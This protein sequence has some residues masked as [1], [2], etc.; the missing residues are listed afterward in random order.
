MIHVLIAEDEP[1]TL[2][3]IAAMVE[4]ADGAF[5][6]VGTA[7]NGKEA[8]KQIEQKHVDVVMTDIRM[9]VMDG[10]ELM[11]QIKTRYSHIILVVLSGYQDYEYMAHAIRARSLDYLLKPVSA[12]AMGQLLGRVKTQYLLESR[13]R[14]SRSLALHLN[15]AVGAAE[16]GHPDVRLGVCLFCAGGLPRG[17]DAEM[18]PAAQLWAQHALEPL[19]SRIV[20]GFTSFTWEFMGATPVERILVY[21][22]QQSTLAPWAKCLHETLLNQGGI[23]VSCTAL[24]EGVP[25][26]QINHQLKRLRQ[27]LRAHIR[28]GKSLFVSLPLREDHG[29][30]PAPAQDW[31]AAAKL[32][33]L[34]AEGRVGQA[35]PFRRELFQRMEREGWTQA[36]VGRL[37]EQAATILDRDERPQVRQAASGYG[38]ALAEAV[39]TALSLRELEK[40]L[41]SLAPPEGTGP[42]EQPRIREVAGAIEAY[43]RDHYFEHI[44]N[45]TLA[46]QFG[47]VPSY[48]SLLFRQQ[49]RQSPS[50]YLT[51][52]R[53]DEAKKLMQAH[54]DMLIREVAERVGFKSQHHFSRIFKKNEGMWPTSYQA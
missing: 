30:A 23:P 24:E 17:E 5:S 48:I 47:Y 6:V 19:A 1:P 31:E 10:M 4:Q 3:R 16:Q 21:Q 20:P 44:T 15:R 14:L 7:L 51:R 32:A 35:D 22:T 53:L 46:A 42:A 43:L 8:L 2:R 50:E 38:A 45:Q 27:V 11:D 39:D 41:C 37:F 29:S 9:P 25:L 28:I 33:E 26:E 12:Q 49:Y 40:N 36:R 54:P 18:Y 34:L 52:L 13:E